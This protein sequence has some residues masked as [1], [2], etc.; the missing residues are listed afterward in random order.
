MK[1]TDRYE[2][3]SFD[4]LP[5]FTASDAPEAADSKWR[6][7]IES[8]RS[9]KKNSA[10]TIYPSLKKEHV[11]FECQIQRSNSDLRRLL[12]KGKEEAR[13]RLLDL[14]RRVLKKKGRS[15]T[16]RREKALDGLFA[17]VVFVLDQGEPNRFSDMQAEFGETKLNESDWEALE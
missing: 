13:E 1:P 12:P 7:S 4:G 10:K 2:T 5:S 6:R 14:K 15:S 3:D 11:R 17:Q 16:H 8:T 9:L